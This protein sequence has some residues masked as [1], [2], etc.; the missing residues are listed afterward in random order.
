MDILKKAFKY[1]LLFIIISYIMLASFIFTPLYNWRYARDNGFWRWLWFGE[2]VSTAKA[3]IWPYYIFYGRE[4]NDIQEKDYSRPNLNKEEMD[5]I[6][7]VIFKAKTEKLND[8]D[9]IMLKSG[10]EIYIKRTGYKFTNKEIAMITSIIDWLY[11]YRYEKG[12]CL[13]MSIEK[14]EPIIT[15]EYEE[16]FNKLKQIGLL[17]DSM[18]EDD[19]KLI[20]SAGRRTVYTDPEGVKHYPVTK[21]HV[22]SGMEKDEIL[23][24]NSEEIKKV[25]Y[26]LSE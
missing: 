1:I 2:I 4:F 8:K 23:K 17:E 12:K 18:L 3:M 20:I 15:A 7:G 6:G 25:L 14:N 5:L 19:K 10:Y 16:A 9:L 21:K 11:Q 13:L 24:N 26:E 22:I